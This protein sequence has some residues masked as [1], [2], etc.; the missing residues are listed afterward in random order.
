MDALTQIELK[1][2]NEMIT[3]YATVSNDNNPIHLSIAA[4]NEAGFPKQVAHGMLLIA[5]SSTLCTPLIEDGWFV[6]HFETKFI[7]PLFVDDKLTISIQSISHQTEKLIW[8]I[9]GKKEKDITV[10]NGK[11]IFAALS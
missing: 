3:Q 6:S 1:I 4:A 2:T 10:F 5:L 11:V 8:H 9:C 7:S